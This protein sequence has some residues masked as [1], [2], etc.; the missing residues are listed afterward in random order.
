MLSAIST[1]ATASVSPMERRR[2]AQSSCGSPISVSAMGAAISTPS[3]S[4]A[5]QVHQV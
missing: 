5:H 2:G 3:V 1:V 4:P